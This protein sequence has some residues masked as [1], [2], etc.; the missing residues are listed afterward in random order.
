PVSA[1]SFKGLEVPPR[2]AIVRGYIPDLTPTLLSGDG[3]AGKSNIAL[4]LAVAR[5][6]GR[7][8]LGLLPEEGSTLVLSAED[9][10]NEMH[11]RLDVILKFYAAQSPAS[12]D[13]MADI[14]LVDLVGENSILALPSRG[15]IEPTPLYKALDI[16]MGDLRSD[17]V[18][19]D[20]LADMFAGDERSR[21]Q[22]RQ[23]A[24]LL[25]ALTKRHACGLLLLAHPS[26]TGM[27]TGT[28]LSG[29]T[30]WNNAFRSRCYF[31]SPKTEEGVEVNKNLR[32][33]EG[34]KNNREELGGPIDVE[35]KNGVFVPVNAPGGFSKMAADRK[36]DDVF[37]GL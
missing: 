5:I 23:F 27:N 14:R 30:D 3:G 21:S 28:G 31:Y 11:R 1:A 13:D 18:I 15:I 33:F 7:D 17:L 20:V 10:L 2:R 26:L 22:V 19:L 35:W 34:K 25:H 24:N 29:S 9:D 6:L 36:A 12:W 16:Y 4:Q 8:W 32:V 37:L